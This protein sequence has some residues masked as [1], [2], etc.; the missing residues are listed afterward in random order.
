MDVNVAVGVAKLSEEGVD[1]FRCNDV[2]YSI[3]AQNPV[4][5]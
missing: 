3:E 5:A 2:V 1:I 4:A